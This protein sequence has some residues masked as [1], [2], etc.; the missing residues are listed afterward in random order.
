MVRWANWKYVYYAGQDP[1]LFDLAA[2][3]HELDDLGVSGDPVA[4]AARASST[5]DSK[6][7]LGM[8][9]DGETST[10]QRKVV[11]GRLSSNSTRPCWTPCAR[12]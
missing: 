8:S 6:A 1:Q 12:N 7:R 3:P 11:F 9:I 10:L 5:P 2:D 4:A